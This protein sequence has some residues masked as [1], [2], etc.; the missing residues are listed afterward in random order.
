MPLGVFEAEPDPLGR[1]QRQRINKAGASNTGATSVTVSQLNSGPTN[2]MVPNLPSGNLGI[3]LQPTQ[4]GP[5][6][7][8]EKNPRCSGTIVCVLFQ[9]G[10]PDS[11]AHLPGPWRLCNTVVRTAMR[12]R[13]CGLITLAAQVVRLFR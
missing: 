3:A 8:C 6:V 10:S 1:L 13:G 9:T 2:M 4:M 12:D 11:R 7:N 5:N